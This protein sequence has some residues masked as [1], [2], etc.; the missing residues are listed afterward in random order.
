M[1]TS[2]MSRA[3]LRA[4]ALGVLAISV[5]AAC[6]RQPPAAPAVTPDPAAVNAPATA[7]AP[8]AS[9]AEVLPTGVL[10]AYVWE[11]A[12]GQTL[13]MRN[14]LREKAVAIDFHDGTRRLDQVVSAS[15]ARYADA[16]VTFWTKGSTATIERQGAAPVQ[17]EE[18]RALSLRE[19]ARARGVVYRALGNEP[20]WVLEIGPGAALVWVTDFGSTTHSFADAQQ[21]AGP[22]GT[23]RTYS[24]GSGDQA[25][26][27]TV[28][29]ERC[30]DD[31]G[32]E[33]DHSATLETGGQSLRGCGTRL[34]PG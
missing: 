28:R 20:G 12:D 24:A 15:G 6:Q 2:P 10:R 30:V 3:V 14:L 18:R 4:A 11:C 17:C 7:A 23:S 31:G 16:V 19:D 26:R 5:L 29:Q 8:A 33:F 34:N 1:Y 9:P 13:V 21:T 32:V 27:V 22:D 25:I